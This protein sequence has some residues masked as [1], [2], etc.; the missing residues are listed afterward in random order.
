MN[1]TIIHIITSLDVGGAENSLYKLIASN[2]L[3]GYTSIV[4]CLKGKGVFGK[5]LMREGI[6]VIYLDLKI[7][8]FLKNIFM[9]IRLIKKTNPA[10]IQGWMYHGNLLA[11]L[12]KEFLCK[13]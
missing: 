7:Y 9:L 3:L 6:K 11:F 8:N 1:N 2:N 5:K 4:I 13:I 12:L 10:L